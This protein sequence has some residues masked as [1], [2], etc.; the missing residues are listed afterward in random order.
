MK[1]RKPITTTTVGIEYSLENGYYFD[2]NADGLVDSIFFRTNIKELKENLKEIVNKGYKSKKLN[3]N[4]TPK[5]YNVC[6]NLAR[7]ELEY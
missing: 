3:N 4:I 7:L 5:R 2:N 1:V 6:P